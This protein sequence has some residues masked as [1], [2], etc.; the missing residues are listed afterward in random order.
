MDRT[1]DS[2]YLH[3]HPTEIIARKK[4]FN[5]NKI[6]LKKTNLFFFNLNIEFERSN[7]KPIKMV[8]KSIIFQKK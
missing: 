8:K 4:N 2:F 3:I 7:H 6:P 5:E 1:S